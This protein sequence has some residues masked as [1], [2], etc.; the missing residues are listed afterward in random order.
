[1]RPARPVSD[2]E[3]GVEILESVVA[4][5]IAGAEPSDGTPDPRAHAAFVARC[6]YASVPT[7]ITA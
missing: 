6:D 5:A 3:R 7:L 1:M 2:Q 4:P